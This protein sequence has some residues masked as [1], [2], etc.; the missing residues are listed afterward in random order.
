MKNHEAKY[1]FANTS[2]G[3]FWACITDNPDQ[4]IMT[5]S[6]FRD[7]LST[8]EDKDGTICCGPQMFDPDQAAIV[9]EIKEGYGVK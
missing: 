6:D 3:V 2:Q 5:L 1:L 9:E 8:L 7:E 4:D